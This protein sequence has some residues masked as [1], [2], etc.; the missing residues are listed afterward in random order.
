MQNKLLRFKVQTA[1]I[2][3]QFWNHIFFI[4]VTQ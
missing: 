4:S 2:R 3:N 1:E